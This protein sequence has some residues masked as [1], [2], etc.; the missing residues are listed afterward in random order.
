MTPRALVLQ[1]EEKA[2]AG[3]LAPWLE[4]VGL[5]CDILPAHEGYAVP[6]DLG[7]HAALVVLGGSMDAWDD[8]AYRW[9]LPTRALIA[10][11]VSAGRPFLGVCLGHQLAALAL[12]GT[13]GRQPGG[14]TMGLRAWRPT[15][16]GLADPLTSALPP[17]TEVLHF[18]SDA[19]T[20]LPPGATLLAHDPEGTVQAARYGPLAWGVQ[21]HPEVDDALVEGWATGLRPDD[22][23]ETVRVLRERQAE[24]HPAWAG[25]VHRFG[26]LATTPQARPA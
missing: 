22:E 7:D 18:N 20:G 5:E 10:G 24:L 9:L 21:F 4:Q 19:V 26:L 3:L 23:T 14:Q 17:G 6:A 1:H 11:T 2:P 13:V 12:G 15:P 25:L 16:A 8:E